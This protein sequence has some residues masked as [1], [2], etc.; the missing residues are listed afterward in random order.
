MLTGR[1]G[2]YARFIRYIPVHVIYDVLTRP[3]HN[4]LLSIY[5]LTGCDTVSAF[6][7]HGKK[8]TFK[9]LMN[10]ADSFQEVARLGDGV[11]DSDSVQ[12]LKNW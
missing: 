11:Q 8:T 2:K 5:C 6:H 1:T 4:V 9:M 10:R 7:G 3:Q 12:V